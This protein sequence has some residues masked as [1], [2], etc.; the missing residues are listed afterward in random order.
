MHSVRAEYCVWRCDDHALV[1]FIATKKAR[2]YQQDGEITHGYRGS[3]S[4]QQ[5]EHVFG[6]G[7]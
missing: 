3:T 7:N 1:L 6:C 2:E 5:R 4:D